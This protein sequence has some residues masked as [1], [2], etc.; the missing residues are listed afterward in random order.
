MALRI[1][2]RLA[3][4]IRAQ[5]NAAVP[6]E[7]CGLLLGAGDEVSAIAPAANVAADPAHRF[8]IDP[9]ILLAAHKAARGSGPAILGCY[10]SHPVGDPV[11]SVTDAAMAEGRGEYW[12][13][14][15]NEG[16]LR[17]WRAVGGG[18]FEAIQLLE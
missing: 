1:S 4:A 6:L 13:I 16:L 2:R 8:E 11:P 9:M 12:L 15:G 17:G 3:D 7:C 10:H 5:A 14:V 18:D